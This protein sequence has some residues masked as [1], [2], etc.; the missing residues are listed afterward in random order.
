MA[1]GKLLIV[2]RVL[3]DRMET[4]AGHRFTAA[5]DLLMMVAA[6]GRER[7]EGEYRALLK[8]SGFLLTRTVAT[9][10]HYTMIEAQ[11]A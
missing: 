5:S 9:A 8:S 10:A 7:T 3:P 1:T 6:S 4:C 2:E 11:H